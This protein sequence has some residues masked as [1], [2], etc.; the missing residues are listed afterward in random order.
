[1]LKK[2]L[3]YILSI[4]CF[5]FLNFS[6][7]FSQ[8]NDLT[9]EILVNK[10]FTKNQKINFSYNIKSKELID[11]S[12]AVSVLCENQNIPQKFPEIINKKISSNEVYQGVYEGELVLP[13]VFKSQKCE[14]VVDIVKPFSKTFKKNFFIN[15]ISDFDYDLL[16]CQNSTCSRKKEVFR[17]DE[18]FFV[19]FSGHQEI[20]GKMIVR[21]PDGEIS[22]TTLPAWY[23]FPKKGVYEIKG[24]LDLADFNKKAIKKTINV[25]ASGKKNN[26]L[27]KK[28]FKLKSNKKNI[29]WKQI[30]YLFVFLLIIILFL[31]FVKKSRKK[32]DQ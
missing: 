15:T 28:D 18:K 13:D 16:F 20:P 12:F 4:F 3:F 25:L 11:L 8:E 27:S 10:V 6:F 17:V 23:V 26:N 2:K 7:V 22:T 31:F 29:S 14:A 30:I 9:V 32:N 5:L 21:F 24:F 1:M 19:K